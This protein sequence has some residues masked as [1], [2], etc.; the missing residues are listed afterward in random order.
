MSPL[1]RMGGLKLWPLARMR[2]PK[3]QDAMYPRTNEPRRRDELKRRTALCA[4]MRVARRS[5]GRSGRVSP[6][7]RS[8]RFEK[9]RP[10]IATWT[11]PGLMS[12]T[13]AAGPEPVVTLNALAVSD[14]GWSTW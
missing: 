7:I 13:V 4:A 3:R 1:T 11:L 9:V 8:R 5:R 10:E 14:G 12:T 2:V 6:W